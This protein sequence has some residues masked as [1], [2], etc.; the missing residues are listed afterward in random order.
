LLRVLADLHI[1]STHSDGKSSPLEIVQVALEK[2]LRVISITDHDTFS[3]SMFAQRYA[4]NS[5]VL[6][7][8]GV[9]V[10][11][12]KGDILMYCEKEVDFPRKIDLLIEKAHKENCL[13][14]P[15]HPFDIMRLGIGDYVFEV[16][17]WDAIEV[18]NS[19]ATKGSNYKAIE[20]ARMLGKPGL[21]NSDAHLSEEIGSAYNILEIEEFNTLSVLEAIR[22][23]RV[24]PVF[25]K[26]P[27]KT[28]INRLIWSAERSIK[29]LFK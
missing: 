7:I 21:A 5:D 12:D 13:I 14:V 26:T 23:N 11:T 10:R 27:F 20:A 8:P 16:N 9:E 25:G 4:S 24:K 18:W 28:R 15:A 19:S 2:G 22:K 1:H 3:G 17:E 6:V 29:T